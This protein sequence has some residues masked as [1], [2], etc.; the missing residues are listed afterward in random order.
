MVRLEE[1]RQSVRIIEQAL[2]QMPDEVPV[3]VD[4]P[5]IVYP[6]KH[7][8]YTTIE[9]TIAHFKLVM[10]GLRVPAGRGLQLHRGRQR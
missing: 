5:R 10:E 8:V 2:E 3:N 9:A 7:D 4:D 1:I 6:E